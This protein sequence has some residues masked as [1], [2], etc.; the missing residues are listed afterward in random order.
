MLGNN[1]GRVEQIIV[2]PELRA[3]LVIR[4]VP[5]HRPQRIGNASSLFMSGNGVFVE[6][7]GTLRGGFDWGLPF[8]LGRK[9]YVGFDKKG[10]QLGT[11]PYWA[12]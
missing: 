6:M 10:S 9:V 1:L 7:G 4:L 8:F 2:H 3:I 12:Y 5:V 11:G